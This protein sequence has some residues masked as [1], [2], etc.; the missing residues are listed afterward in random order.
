M[1]KV[2]STK[3]S[4]RGQRSGVSLVK[5]GIVT[6]VL[7]ILTACGSGAGDPVQN[8]PTQALEAP[9]LSHLSDA[10]L[11]RSAATGS[12]QMRTGMDNVQRFAQ[13]PSMA[14][15]MNTADAGN[16]LSRL[17]GMSG[18][19][20]SVSVD[21]INSD[22][23]AYDAN[24][25][26]VVPVDTTPADD[27]PADM[28]FDNDEDLWEDSGTDRLIDITLGLVGDADVTRAGDTVLVNPDDQAL[29]NVESL[30]MQSA[31]EMQFCLAM[32]TDLRVRIDGQT[33]ASG[34]VTYLYQEEP[35]F[36]VD[37][38]PQR[39]SYKLY[40][41]GIHKVLQQAASIAPDEYGDIPE[42]FEGVIELGVQID[43][44]TFGQEAGSI[45]LAIISPI[46]IEA[47]AAG[48]GINIAASNLFR[49]ENNEALGAASIELDAGAASYYFTD[50]ERI[51]IAS[52]GSTFKIDFVDDGEQ[53]SVS[54]LGLGRGP[55]TVSIDSV[56]VARVTLE[57]FGF[58]IDTIS[59]QLMLTSELDLD[60]VVNLVSEYFGGSPEESFRF[61]L[62][63]TAPTNATFIAQKNGSIKLENAGPVELDW[64]ASF[65]GEMGQQNYLL[66]EGECFT[67]DSVGNALFSLTVCD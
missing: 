31:Q 67:E 32:V 8:S 23:V 46:A 59:R 29:C 12:K 52:S 10:E 40:L 60:I 7:F 6:A 34:L 39:A 50:G 13:S 38:A 53:I 56:E 58:D 55:L 30:D 17:M 3:S 19:S 36:S 49:F 47:Q 45:N 42:Q 65:G 44:D 43:N 18:D 66:R 1:Q 14:D 25:S 33:E 63:A 62:S 27:Q 26:P 20:T 35:M 2:A 11:Q 16:M 28:V 54:K 64:F 48:A 9:A 61:G 21:S 15:S 22:D 57:T 24:G 51:D 37:Y 4:I 41:L 5:A